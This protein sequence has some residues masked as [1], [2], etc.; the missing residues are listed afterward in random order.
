MIVNL[1]AALSQAYNATN[2]TEAAEAAYLA[3]KE[4]LEEK[5][6]ELVEKASP[7]RSTADLAVLAAYAW[8]M[9]DHQTWDMRGLDALENGDCNTE[10]AARLILAVLDLA[11]VELG[12]GAANA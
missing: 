7:P 8:W 4:P 6:D 11:G 5:L 1:L 9:A 2:G 10:P 12:V 3:A